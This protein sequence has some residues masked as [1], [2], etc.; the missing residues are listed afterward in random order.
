MLCIL[1]INSLYLIKL[2]KQ[3]YEKDRKK[4]FRE[5]WFALFQ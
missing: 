5:G 3:Q 4:L 2:K 1:K